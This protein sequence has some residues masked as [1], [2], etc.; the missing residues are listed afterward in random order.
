[1]GNGNDY[2]SSEEHFEN[3]KT[4]WGSYLLLELFII[5]KI[6]EFYLV[7]LVPREY[8][9]FTFEKKILWKQ[10]FFFAFWNELLYLV[11]AKICIL[12]TD[13]S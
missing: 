12:K 2:I 13:N 6:I 9:K 1:M 10:S 11:F 8:A 5:V 4:R 3:W 7:I